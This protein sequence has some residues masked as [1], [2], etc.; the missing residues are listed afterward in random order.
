MAPEA[1]HIDSKLATTISQTGLCPRTVNSYCTSTSDPRGN[2][3]E[4]QFRQRLRDRLRICLNQNRCDGSK[5]RKEG[6]Q[7]GIRGALRDV[8]TIILVGRDKCPPHQAPKLSPNT[9]RYEI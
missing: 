3:L 5:H 9:G 8:E 7:S 6:Q 4:Q 2:D 1:A